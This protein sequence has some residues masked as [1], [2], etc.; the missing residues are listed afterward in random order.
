MILF[1]GDVREEADDELDG[2]EDVCTET[3]Q[4]VDE[5]TKQKISNILSSSILGTVRCLS[6]NNVEEFCGIVEKYFA[7]DE[8]DWADLKAK[9]IDAVTRGPK[10][11]VNVVR[12]E[13]TT[14]KKNDILKIRAFVSHSNNSIEPITNVLEGDVL[15][16][17]EFNLDNSITLPNFD[18]C[19]LRMEVLKIRN[20]GILKGRSLVGVKEIPLDTIPTQRMESYYDLVKPEGKLSLSS[21]VGHLY[22]S[23]RKYVQHGEDPNITV[24]KILTEYFSQ[25]FSDYFQIDLVKSDPTESVSYT[26]NVERTGD[27]KSVPFQTLICRD[28]TLKPNYKTASTFSIDCILSNKLAVGFEK[29]KKSSLPGV[30]SANNLLSVAA[31]SPSL[32][33]ARSMMSLFSASTA[34]L[35]E[36]GL[37]TPA[38]TS[39]ARNRPVSDV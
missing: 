33:P 15:G 16:E 35:H 17:T 13:L 39:P 32:S 24:P 20:D 3:D 2:G 25:K 21:N 6:E 9:I 22:I 18:D 7:V 37:D 5:G 14:V 4:Q 29:I 28:K 19:V 31:K 12:G 30:Q 26:L 27:T 38:P 11:E 8:G 10:I 23:L 34:S 1:S 36:S